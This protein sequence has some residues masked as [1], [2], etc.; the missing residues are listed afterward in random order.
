MGVENVFV[1]VY[2]GYTNNSVE[3]RQEVLRE[4][5]EVAFGPFMHSL[6][7]KVIDDNFI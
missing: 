7:Q 2:L 1:W 4:F 6:V 3:A 5:F